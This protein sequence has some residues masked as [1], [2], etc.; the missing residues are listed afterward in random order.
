MHTTPQSST[1]VAE[2][3][4]RWENAHFDAYTSAEIV[5]HH[6][7]AEAAHPETERAFKALAAYGPAVDPQVLAEFQAQLDARA[8]TWSTRPDA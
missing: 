2:A 1:S 7:L 8:A 3:V 4:A 5:L 6:D